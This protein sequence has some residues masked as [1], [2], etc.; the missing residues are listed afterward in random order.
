MHQNKR[1]V[2]S[3]LPLEQTSLDLECCMCHPLSN[4]R[5]VAA[6]EDD[7]EEKLVMTNVTL[8]NRLCT[9]LQDFF[10]RSAPLSIILLHISQREQAPLG[11]QPNVLRKRKCY[12]AP[13]S[14]IEQVITSMRRALRSSDQLL[15]QESSG[16]ALILPHV[17]Q[18]GS[19][20]VLDRIYHHISLLQAQTVIPPLTRETTL[21]MSCASF[22]SPASTQEEL[23]AL[24][25]PI[26]RSFVLRPVLM[27]QIWR[28]KPL[29][30]Q[31]IFPDCQEQEAEYPR[32]SSVPFMA[33]PDEV[34][35]RLKHLIPHPIAQELRCVPV[36]RDQQALTVAMLDPTDIVTLQRLQEITKMTIFPVLC[37]E[38]D[39]MQI[40]TR[41]W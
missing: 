10:P 38:E 11:A 17:D 31:K 4:L 37:K 18:S 30:M 16:I 8:N 23:L 24:T 14:F 35:A 20:R 6:L 40:L 3:P 28:V 21:L 13:A 32:H 22:P 15:L 36:G 9:V 26:V 29:S 39:L 27:N 25:A 19:Y 34:P 1:G 2:S 41:G 12:H 5:R 33:L 7:W